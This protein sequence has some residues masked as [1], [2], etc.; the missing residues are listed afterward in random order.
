M[1]LVQSEREIAHEFM[2]KEMQHVAAASDS[3]IVRNADHLMTNIDID[4]ET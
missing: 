4:K 3:H 1:S 2:V